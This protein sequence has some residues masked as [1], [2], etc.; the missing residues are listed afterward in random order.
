M[1]LQNQ[2]YLLIPLEPRGMSTCGWLCMKIY[3]ESSRTPLLWLKVK[4]YHDTL[5]VELKEWEKN[6]Q[7]CGLLY[8]K[9]RMFLLRL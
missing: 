7:P 2:K 6:S 3:H 1:L 4:T 5:I 8:S 9:V